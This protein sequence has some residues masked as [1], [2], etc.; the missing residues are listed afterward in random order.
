MSEIAVSDTSCVRHLFEI[1]QEK[2]LTIFTTIYIPVQVKDE[3]LAQGV[4]EGLEDSILELFQ[5]KSVAEREIETILTTMSS[6]DL[7]YADASVVVVAKEE[8]PSAVLTD[9]LDLRKALESLRFTVVGSIGVLIRAFKQG[10]FGKNDLEAILNDLF[11]DST[12]YL[13]KAFKAQVKEMIADLPEH[14]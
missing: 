8:N 12:L 4:W 3:L 9:D 14:F 11:T 5:I 7:H 10:R 13:S 6:F 2:T 1:G